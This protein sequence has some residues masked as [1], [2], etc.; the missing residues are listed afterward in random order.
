VP[1]SKFKAAN[2]TDFPVPVSPVKTENPL[3]NPI[4]R[5]SIKT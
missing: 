5:L 4:V 3:L 1:E 2:I